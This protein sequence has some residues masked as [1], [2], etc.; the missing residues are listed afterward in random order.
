MGSFESSASWCFFANSTHLLNRNFIGIQS[1]LPSSCYPDPVPF[2]HG[3]KRQPLRNRGAAASACKDVLECGMGRLHSKNM[4]FHYNWICDIQWIKTLYNIYMYIC[5]Y[6]YISINICLCIYIY[7]YISA[8]KNKTAFGICC[9]FYFGFYTIY[10]T[11]M[12][13]I[14]YF[15]YQKRQIQSC[16]LNQTY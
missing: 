3:A 13:H 11:S 5:V 6:I 1:L 9:K 2:T 7:I 8:F 4:Y 12:F 10:H 16:M 14:F 15:E